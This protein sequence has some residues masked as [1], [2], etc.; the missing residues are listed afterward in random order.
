MGR[1]VLTLI[2]VLQQHVRAMMEDRL[3]DR[4]LRLDA[5]WPADTCLGIDV[6][7]PQ[8]VNTLS[9]LARKTLRDVDLQRLATFLP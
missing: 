1:L 5:D 7:T 9:A 2:A 3:G 6:A 4:C 8:A